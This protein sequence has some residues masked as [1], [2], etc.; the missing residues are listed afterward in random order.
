MSNVTC[1]MSH[2]MCNM[3]QF[4]S[5]FF[6]GQ[7][8]EAYWWTVCYQR[9]LPRLV[10]HISTC[11]EVSRRV[12]STCALQYCLSI[13]F[14]PSFGYKLELQLKFTCQLGEAKAQDVLPEAPAALEGIF[15]HP[16]GNSFLDFSHPERTQV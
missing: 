10:L 1:L 5:S 9:G 13:S 12:I 7:S 2:V 3:T 4:F 14:C 8:G 16:L 6:C 15:L 11:Q